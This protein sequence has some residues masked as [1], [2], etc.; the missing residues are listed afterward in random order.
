[1]QKGQCQSWPPHDNMFI[2]VAVLHALFF[3]RAGSPANG[4]QAVCSQT[5]PETCPSAIFTLPGP[6][7]GPRRRHDL[8]AWRCSDKEKPLDWKN[9]PLC[10]EPNC[11]KDDTLQGWTYQRQHVLWVVSKLGDPHK[12]WFYVV[13]VTRKSLQVAVDSTCSYVDGFSEL[14]PAQQVNYFMGVSPPFLGLWP[15][16]LPFPP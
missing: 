3:R 16:T 13:L 7:T 6:S 1:M 15:R 2:R 14:C 9:K 10:T 8:P 4:T 5:E 12:E 11:T